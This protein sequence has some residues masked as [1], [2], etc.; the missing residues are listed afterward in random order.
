MENKNVKLMR[1]KP[2]IAIKKLVIPIII[3]MLITA[4]Y[5]IIEDMLSVG[6]GR[7]LLYA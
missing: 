6:M 2:E 7:I 4:S 3:S 5:N 1:G